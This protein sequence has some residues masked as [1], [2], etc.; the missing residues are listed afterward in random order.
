LVTKLNKSFVENHLFYLSLLGNNKPYHPETSLGWSPG[1]GLPLLVLG[2]W[3]E[4]EFMKFWQMDFENL[5][6]PSKLSPLLRNQSSS[7]D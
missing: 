6:P 1:P 2:K 4:E 5:S 7:K 3:M